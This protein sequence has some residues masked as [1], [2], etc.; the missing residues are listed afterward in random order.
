M[1]TNEGY[2]KFDLDWQYSDDLAQYNIDDTQVSDLIRIKRILQSKGMIG[3]FDN[4]I[5][6]GNVSK[7]ISGNSFLISGTQTGCIDNIGLSHFALVSECN[8]NRNY[9]KCYGSVRASSE[10]MTHFA[11]YDTA[12]QAGAIIHVH[13]ENLWTKLIDKVPTTNRTAEFGTPEIALEIQRLIVENSLGESG[14]IIMGGHPDGIITF[15]KDIDQA[16][17]ILN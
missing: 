7:R 3:G 12:S 1:K 16:Y 4:G 5:N 10:S 13:S 17:S 9:I 11:V 8:I 14:I 15:G 2:I 6:F